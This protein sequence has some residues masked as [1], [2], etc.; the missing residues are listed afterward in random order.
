MKRA[1]GGFWA[2][3]FTMK[4]KQDK[5]LD[6]RWN[7]ISKKKSFK[8]ENVRIEINYSDTRKSKSISTIEPIVETLFF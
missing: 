1:D 3:K 2:W 5:T 4:R 7:N 6:E 8:Y